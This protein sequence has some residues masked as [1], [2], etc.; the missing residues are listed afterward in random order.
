MT[1]QV[2][3]L[4]AAD[5]I[6]RSHAMAQA[7]SQQNVVQLEEV[8]HALAGAAVNIGAHALAR[9]CSQLEQA[10]SAGRMPVQATQLV[11]QIT[12][13]A[14]QSVAALQEFRG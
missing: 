14:A 4:F 1:R 9:E 6:R 10:C 3:N 8:A 2:L 12:Q 5:A 11:Q 13:L 7:L